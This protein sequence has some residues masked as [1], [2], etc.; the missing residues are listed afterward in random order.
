[1]HKQTATSDPPSVPNDAFRTLPQK[2]SRVDRNLESR[3][4]GSGVK[5]G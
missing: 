3:V 4:K 1:M 5:P 2:D